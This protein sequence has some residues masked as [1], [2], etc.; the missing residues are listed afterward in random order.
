VAKGGPVMRPRDEPEAKGG[1][2][3]EPGSGGA[4]EQSPA[5]AGAPASGGKRVA[6]GLLCGVAAVALAAAVPLRHG[7]LAASPWKATAAALRPADPAPAVP[8]GGLPV[9][10]GDH[11][12][13]PPL[14]AGGPSAAPAVPT[15]TA[16]PAVDPRVSRALETRVC[17]QA[18]KALLWTEIS[19]LGVRLTWPAAGEPQWA[20]D[21]RVFSRGLRRLARRVEHLPRN[22]RLLHSANGFHTLPAAPG[23]VLDRAAARR[24]LLAA[25]VSP[26]YRK[27][28]DASLPEKP[29]PIKL[30]LPLRQVLPTVTA[31]HLGAINTLLASY[32]TGLGSSSRNRRHNIRVACAA[33]DGTVLLPGEV[34]SYNEIVGPR[35]ERAGFRT[36]P[37]IIHGELVPG[38]GGGI[39]QVSTTLYNVALLGDLK[40]VRRSHHE[41]PV[42]YVP[43]GRDATVAYGSLDLR[44]ANS[45]PGPVALDVKTAGSRVVVHLYGTAACKRDVQLVS[46]R[47]TRTRP[48]AAAGG[49]PPRPGKRVTVTRMVRRDD[50]TVRRE[51]I[52]HDSYAPPPLSSH[53]SLNHRPRG[54]RR[55]MSRGRPSAAPVGHSLVIKPLASAGQP[56][57]SQ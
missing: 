13:P 23:R 53:A 33:I 32:S 16:P 17:L 4:P 26:A 48:R 40:I 34:F 3:A 38:T 56:A 10:E 50:G 25:L 35:T 51:V 49:G 7:L 24:Q 37:V 20:L 19:R 9:S 11:A 36:A 1:G 57:G 54:R 39:C 41:F 42:H 2:R 55:R 30:S 8:A 18:G 15:P 45:L 21:D 29:A 44:F 27:S 47:V 43:P 12:V 46:S 22:A 52:S 28:L 6:A 31:A 14:P 5:G